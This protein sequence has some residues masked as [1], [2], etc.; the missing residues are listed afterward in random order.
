MATKRDDAAN[1][2]IDSLSPEFMLCRDLGHNWLPYRAWKDAKEREYVQI[3]QCSRCAAERRRRLDF[4]G[5]RVSN[6]Y[7][8][9]DGYVAPAGSGVMSAAGRADLRLASLER[10]VEETST[11]DEVA[12]R[13][14]KKGA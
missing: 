1:K 13:R 10:L 9:S 12:A 14:K 3:L 6:A 5:N 4:R 2:W 8:Y 11:A 7:D